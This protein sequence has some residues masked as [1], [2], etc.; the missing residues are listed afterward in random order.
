M[1]VTIEIQRD[2]VMGVVEGISVIISQKNG[3]SPSFEQLWA[4]ED[5]RKKL[6]IYYREAVSDLE[7]RLMEW[8]SESSSQ[9]TLTEE[10]EDYK[11]TLDMHRY[12]P[13][14][15][16]GLLGNKLQDYLVH[17][18]TAGWLNDFKEVETKQDYSAMAGNDLADI[19]EVVM[20]K[21]FSF[22]EDARSDDAEKGAPEDVTP[23]DARASDS[24]KADEEGAT[25]ADE[26]TG[27]ADKEQ[28]G[29]DTPAGERSGDG[30]KE[31][32]EAVSPTG[33]RGEDTDKGSSEEGSK[34]A[35]RRSDTYKADSDDNDVRTR[36]RTGDAEHKNG[37]W[38]PD[39][40]RRHEDDE[41]F[42]DANK[43]VDAGARH[44]DDARVRHHSDWTDWSGTHGKMRM[45]RRPFDYDEA[46]D[47]YVEEGGCDGRR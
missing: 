45:Q 10:G 4:S 25:H 6:D 11:L 30:D 20:Q 33:A 2:A 9:Y 34:G 46:K 40:H 12:W 13:V 47:Y 24:D 35:K 41:A 26:R 1:K 18:I 42:A 29:S 37:E 43:A 19:R 5:E 3:G 16:K 39:A 15:L 7:R 36:T 31:V 28:S 38:R 23:T 27:D 44:E 8:L 14:R 17:S 22:A 32:P 21:D